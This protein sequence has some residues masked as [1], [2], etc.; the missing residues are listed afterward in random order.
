MSTLPNLTTTSYAV[1]SLLG[2]KPW[3][4]YELT[5]H[6]DR[7][8]G[9]MWPRAA[10]KLYD[11]PKKLVRHGLARARHESVGNRPRTV[12]V[13]TRKGRRALAAWM[14]EPGAGPNLEFEALLKVGFAEF[15]TKADALGSLAA[16]RDWAAERNAVNAAAARAYRAGQGRFQERAAQTMLVGAFLTSFYRMVDEWAEWAARQVADWPDDPAA[17]VPDDCAIR[18]IARRADWSAPETP[19]QADC[20]GGRHPAP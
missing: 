5:Q 6:M 4:T 13:I 9:R 16:T 15:G 11:E 3:S 10:S 14:A 20:L 1:L 12:Y 18:E 7:S 19:D 17:A 2:I 8:V